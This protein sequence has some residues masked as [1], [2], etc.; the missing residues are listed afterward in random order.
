LSSCLATRTRAAACAVLICQLLGGHGLARADVDIP[1]SM[2]ATPLPDIEGCSSGQ[3]AFLTKAWRRAHYFTWRADGVLRHIQ[4]RPAGERVALWNRDFSSSDDSPAV[5]RWFGVYDAARVAFIA[6]ALN[7]AQKRFRMQGDIV[8]GIRTLRCGSPIAPAQDEHIDICPG[9]NPGDDDPPS[10]YHAPVGTIVICPEA[11]KHAHDAD[12]EDHL[13]RAARRFV[14]ELF[15]WLSVHAKYVVDKHVDGVGGEEDKKYYGSAN[16]TH[17]ALNKPSWASRNNDNYAHFARS[18]GIAE[19]TFTVSFIPKESAGTG[20]FF[21]DMSWE[22]LV[23]NRKSLGNK[24]H[25]A[26][27]ESYVIAGKRRYLGIWR[28]GGGNGAL[29]LNNW[30]GFAQTFQDLKQTQDL[31]DVATFETNEGRR[32]LGVWRERPAGRTGDGGLLAGMSWS[33][34]TAQWQ[35]QGNVA[36]LAD[37]E[38]WLVDGARKYLGV[39][40]VGGGSASALFQHDDWDDF[41][42]SADGLQAS[43]QLVDVTR[44]QDADGRHHFLGVWRAGGTSGSLARGWRRDKLFAEWKA[45]SATQTLTDVQIVV[46]LAAELR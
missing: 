16:A 19:P 24:Q 18:V 37:V 41:K 38:T 15:H 27:V 21:T 20:A 3:K 35:A 7:K 30:R 23:A 33:E 6:E 28:I 42:K 46:P 22:Q 8:K 4:S 44:W 17:L 5:R 2:P 45:L 14:H 40:R 13:N 1:A 34:L 43:Q 36:Y 12:D 31:I 39:W 26:R 9:A 32:Y 11:W 25:L 29:F 10:A